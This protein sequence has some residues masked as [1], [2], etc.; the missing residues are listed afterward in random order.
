MLILQIKLL[1]PLFPVTKNSA[2][3]RSQLTHRVP[4]AATYAGRLT[5]ERC[6]R[7]IGYLHWLT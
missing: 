7:V 4:S 3:I 1:A 5:L 2:S 6:W